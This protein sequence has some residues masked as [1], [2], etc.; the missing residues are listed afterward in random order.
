M[1]DILVSIGVIC[2]NNFTYFF[3][4]LES[5]LNQDYP[6]IELIVSDDGSPNFPYKQVEN[7]IAENR[8][9]NIRSLKILNNKENVGTVRNLN[10][11]IKAASGQF[12]CFLAGDDMFYDQHVITKYVEGFQHFDETAMIEVAQTGMYDEKMEK[13]QYYFLRPY[14]AQKLQEGATGDWLIEALIRNPYIPT[15]STFFKKKFFDEFGLFDTNYTLIE[16]VPTH[17]EMARKG[18]RFYYHN[19]IAIKHRHGGISHGQ[20]HVKKKSH[21]LYIRDTLR[22]INK[23]IWLLKH[24]YHG[25]QKLELLAKCRAERRWFKSLLPREGIWKKAIW[26]LSNFQLLIDWFYHKPWFSREKA[27]YPIMTGAAIAIG[28]AC[29]AQVCGESRIFQV[30]NWIGWISC[31]LGLVDWLFALIVQ[32][33]YNMIKTPDLAID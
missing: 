8:R 18:Y 6:W 9:Q 33:L 4:A 29:L 27:K 31:G 11:V 5:A 19:F 17:L 16:D 15:T 1:S 28:A 10:R 13:L 26:L 3:E 22:L 12:I 23:E 21:M 25:D 24:E 2:Y 7:Y 20:S 30:L 32:W 14:V